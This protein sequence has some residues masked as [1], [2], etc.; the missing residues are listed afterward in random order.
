MEDS[1][2]P[3]S[4]MATMT[5]PPTIATTSRVRPAVVRA[6]APV[7]RPGEEPV[8]VELSEEPVA[9]TCTIVVEV[10]VLRLPSGKVVVLL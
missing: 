8:V 2:F 4:A 6:A 7:C 10:M 9:W 1:D 5:A 3:H